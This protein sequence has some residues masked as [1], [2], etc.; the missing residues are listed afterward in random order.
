MTNH[1][2][3]GPHGAAACPQPKHK[4]VA[5]GSTGDGKS[6][7]FNALQSQTRIAMSHFFFEHASNTTRPCVVNQQQGR[8]L[9]V[10]VTRLLNNEQFW[11][12]LLSLW[13]CLVAGWTPNVRAFSHHELLRA[14]KEPGPWP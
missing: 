9:S 5:L 11:S 7:V 4:I 10:C 14:P 2:S 12:E 13:L 3:H 6:S 1:N 8:A